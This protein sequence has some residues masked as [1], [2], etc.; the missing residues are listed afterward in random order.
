MQLNS[1]YMQNNSKYIP[2]EEARRRL[3]GMCWGKKELPVYWMEIES[4][5]V[6]I[7]AVTRELKQRCFLGDARQ[8]EVRFFPYLYA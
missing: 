4:W 3:R 6:Y 2:Q 8:P 5:V 7:K 1:K